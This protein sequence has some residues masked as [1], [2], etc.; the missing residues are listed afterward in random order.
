MTNVKLL[1]SG[2]LEDLLPATHIF[3]IV[4]NYKIFCN[5]ARNLSYQLS[6]LLKIVVVALSRNKGSP[7]KNSLGHKWILE[8][9]RLIIK[10]IIIKYTRLSRS[11]LKLIAGSLF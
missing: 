5:Y 4:Q 9:S 11:M 1:M 7:I 3:Y 8:Y 2:S 10:R 6:I